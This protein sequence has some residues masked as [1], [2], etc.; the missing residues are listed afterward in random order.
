MPSWELFEKQSQE[1]KDSVIPPEIKARVAMEMA[2]PLGWERYTGD[3][4]AI[5]G[6]NEFGASAPGDR[7]IK[8]YGFTVENVV[9]HVEKVLK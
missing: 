3:Q 6:I 8:E 4:G 5:I 7:V 1:Y 2:Q 9:N